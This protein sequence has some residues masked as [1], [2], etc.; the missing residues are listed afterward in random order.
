[1]AGWRVG[2]SFQE[3]TE[4]K[5]AALSRLEELQRS[6][7]I[8]AKLARSL[9]GGGGNPLEDYRARLQAGPPRRGCYS[10]I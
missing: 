1:M 3:A 10:Q 8:V 6:C 9:S 5:N 7:N 4:E 2:G